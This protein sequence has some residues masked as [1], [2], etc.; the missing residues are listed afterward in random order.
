MNLAHYHFHCAKYKTASDL[1]R[2][3]LHQCE[4]SG[5]SEALAEILRLQAQVACQQGEYD[6]ALHLIA[7]SIQTAGANEWEAT[8]SVKCKRRFSMHKARLPACHCPSSTPNISKFQLASKLSTQPIA[9]PDFLKSKTPST[10]VTILFLAANPD[11]LARLRTGRELRDIEEQLTLAKQRD[12]LS[13]HR[14]LYH[15]QDITRTILEKAPTII[16]FS[17][18]GLPNGELCFRR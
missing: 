16:H 4:R 15:A 3:A 17:G 1:L 12:Q 5:E 10:Q 14:W 18:H 6:Q 8:A 2:E 7:E 9:S 13:I 11:E